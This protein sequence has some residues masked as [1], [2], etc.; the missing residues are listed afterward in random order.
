MTATLAY[1]GGE[2][3]GFLPLRCNS[4]TLLASRI[5]T[6]RVTAFRRR[7]HLFP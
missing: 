3:A 7:F 6:T 1:F 5:H 2:C 4:E